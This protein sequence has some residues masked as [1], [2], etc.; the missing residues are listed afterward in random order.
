[1]MVACLSFDQT[2]LAK[3]GGYTLLKHLESSDVAWNESNFT[4]T[5][6]S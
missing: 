1:M 4:F 2:L 5:L 6:R 3:L